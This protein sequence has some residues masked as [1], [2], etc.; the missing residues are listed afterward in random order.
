[1]AATYGTI[2]NLDAWIAMISEDHLNDSSLGSLATKIIASQFERLRDG[3]RLF[4]I[5]DPDL[6]TELVTSIIDLDTITLAQIIE[7]NTGITN[8]QDNVFYAV[9]PV[10]EPSG[11]A[12]LAAGIFLGSFA[13]RTRCWI[14]ISGRSAR[15][16]P[17]PEAQR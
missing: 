9:A 7:L 12:M 5:G 15:R 16:A 11:L 2:T 17:G 13:R 8:L 10:P 3:D 4:F 1:L 14:R 6:Q